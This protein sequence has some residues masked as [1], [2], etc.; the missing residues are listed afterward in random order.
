VEFIVE[1]YVAKTGLTAPSG[2]LF[3]V[4]RN[5]WSHPKLGVPPNSREHDSSLSTRTDFSITLKTS[6]AP[7]GTPS[8]RLP[9]AG[10]ILFS[11]P[12]SSQ[13]VFQV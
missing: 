13:A 3:A 12:F 8:F 10:I 4:K 5:H 11:L 2:R 9:R 6:A 7:C 1:K